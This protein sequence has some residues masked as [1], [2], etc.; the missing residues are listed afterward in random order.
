ML[1]PLL[2]QKVR[3]VGNVAP[4]QP[5]WPCHSKHP[6]F[7]EGGV[8]LYSFW[9]HLQDVSLFQRVCWHTNR[10]FGRGEP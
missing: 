6:A 5:D 10:S 8:T 3:F 2:V 4:H 9:T 7:G 1:S